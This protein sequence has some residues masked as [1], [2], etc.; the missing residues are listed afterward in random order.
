MM[1]TLDRPIATMQGLWLRA[2]IKMA[3]PA[4][5]P[6][7]GTV[8]TSMVRPP[9]RVVVLGDST[10]AGCGVDN[11]DESFT[12]WLA[13][14]LSSRTQRPV[15]WQVVGQFG[16]TARRIRY[17]LLSQ[18]G[19]EL[20]AA[21][22]LAGGNDVMGGRHPEEWAADLAAIVDDL[23]D[24]SG[25]VIVAGIPPFALF[26]SVPPTLGRVLRAR[27]EALDEV[28]R[29]I[30]RTRSCATWVT[31]TEA[32]QRHFFAADRFHLSAAGYRRWAQVVADHIPV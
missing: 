19:E 24:R 29:D 31:M 25:Q 8:G 21:V 3:P 4:A 17:R 20:D 16:A 6:T 22:L 5:G 2:T 26:P 27:A 7:S 11:H 13:R 12:G 30:C 32:P 14:E 9:L 18:V 28:S 10:A 15:R 1:K 23:L